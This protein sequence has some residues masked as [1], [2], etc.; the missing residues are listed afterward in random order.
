MKEAVTES[1]IQRFETNYDCL[2]KVLKRYLVL[3][4]GLPNVPNSPKPIFRL[5]NENNLLKNNNISQWLLYANTRIGTAHD[6]DGKKSRCCH[7]INGTIYKGCHCF[8]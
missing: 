4:L 3:S 1:V 8:I 5:A 6:Y 2:W 7:C